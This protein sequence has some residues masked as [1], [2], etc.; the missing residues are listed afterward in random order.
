MPTTGTGIGGRR[1]VRRHVALADIRA[2]TGGRPYPLMSTIW[3]NVGPTGMAHRSRSLRIMRSAYRFVV[4]VFGRGNHRGLPCLLPIG[5][6]YRDPAR[7]ETDDISS[8][9]ASHLPH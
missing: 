1:S 8:P 5:Q 2:A 4:I 6:R 3:P 7:S 9:I